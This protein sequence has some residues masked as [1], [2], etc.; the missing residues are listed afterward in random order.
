MTSP[1]PRYRGVPCPQAS[2]ALIQKDPQIPRQYRGL[3]IHSVQPLEDPPVFDSPSP[4]VEQPEEPAPSQ[5]T[6]PEPIASLLTSLISQIQR[7]RDVVETFFAEVA[8]IWDNLCSYWLYRFLRW[9][10]QFQRNRF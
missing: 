3:S 7:I 2:P 1:P 8:A 9:F 6:D 10:A 4:V 5:E